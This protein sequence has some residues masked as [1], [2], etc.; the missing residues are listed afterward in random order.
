LEKAYAKGYAYRANTI[1]ELAKLI[2]VDPKI[3]RATV[4]RQNELAAKGKDDDFVKDPKYLHKYV[5]GPFY[6]LKGE[7]TVISSNGGIQCNEKFQ[8]IKDDLSVIPGLY[9]TGVLIGS[10]V[11]DTY[12]FKAMTPPISALGGTS[13]GF[14]VAASRMIV[15]DIAADL[16]KK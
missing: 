11:G 3:L 6:A 12:P 9:V 2:G 7:H 13:T 1:E 14:G 10:T 16:K 15:E 8:V 5:K 4:D